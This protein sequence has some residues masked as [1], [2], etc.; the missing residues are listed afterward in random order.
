[1]LKAAGFDTYREIYRLITV[2]QNAV[3][4]GDGGLPGVGARQLRRYASEEDACEDQAKKDRQDAFAA[5]IK[6]RRQYVEFVAPNNRVMNESGYQL[7]LEKSLVYRS[8]G[9]AGESHRVFMLSAELLSESGSTPWVTPAPADPV[10]EPVLSFF[11]AQ[12]GPHDATVVFDGRSRECR[13]QLETIMETRRHFSELWFVYASSKR[14][15]RKVCFAS[16]NRE[17][18]FL[19]LPVSRTQL[20]VQNRDTFNQTGDTTTHESSYT[21]IPQLPWGACPK[22]HTENKRAILGTEPQVP[23][24][25]LYD[26]AMGLPLFWQERKSTVLW[27]QVLKDVMASSVFDASPGSGQ[28]ARACLNKGIQYSGVAKN[29]EHA[30]WLNN[31]LD[32]YA[33]AMV[34]TTGSAFYDADLATLAKEHFQDVTDLIG[35]QDLSPDSEPLADYVV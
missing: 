22:L 25:K 28:L 21:G 27:A 9:R 4:I 3:D 17:T 16:D 33:I 13:K 32:R 7:L 10:L 8:S 19:S 31:V 5:I 24:H 35:Q 1:M 11:S 15:G 18:A 23:S 26:T 30:K 2:A 6:R 14:L 34:S 12:N 20:A 29:T